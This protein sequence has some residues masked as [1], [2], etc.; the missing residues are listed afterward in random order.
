MSNN[1]RTVLIVW[2]VTLLVLSLILPSGAGAAE[3]VKDMASVAGVRSNQLVGYGLVVGLDGTGDQ[4]TQAPFTVQSLKNMLGQLGVTVPPNVNPQLRNVAAV[5]IHADLPPFAKQ[6]QTIDVTVSSIGNAGSLRG[7]T[8]LMTPLK[9]AD[10]QTYAIAQ[11][12]LIVGGFGVAGA[13]GSRVS[14]N[15]P[16]VGRIP[17]G[18]TVEREVP[19]AFAQ[20]DHVTLNLHRHDFTTANR[21][22]DAINDAM[23]PGTARPM[24]GSSVRVSAPRDPG[25][26]VSFISVLENLRVQPGEPPAKVIV[27]S[28]TGTVVIGSNVRVMPAAVSHGSMTVTITERAQ[29]T[30]PAPFGQGE[31]VVTPQTDI[32]VTEEDSRMFLFNPGVT[33]DEI[34]RAVNQVGAAPGDLVSIL[35]ALREAGALRAELIVI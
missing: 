2:A 30:Q 13:D 14:V 5:M 8:L 23:G 34:V 3:R 27:N 20:G 24:D 26:R 4:T 6:G 21:L 9:G 19:S 31:T 35:E 12:N 22:S 32:E 11:G 29:V 15:V 17:N 10:G 18:A 28:R 1:I 33:L 7:G 16:S 25:Q